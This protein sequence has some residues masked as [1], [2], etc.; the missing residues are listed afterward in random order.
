MASISSQDFF[1]SGNALAAGNAAAGVAVPSSQFFG[2]G[3]AQSTPAQT[4]PDQS[5]GMTIGPWFPSKQGDSPVRAGLKT[6]GNLI[7]SAVNSG[8]SGAKSVVQGLADIPK[9]PAA[10]V[11]AYKANG[12]SIFSTAANT[13]AGLYENA[14]PTA[15]QGL[16]TVGVGAVTKNQDKVTQGLQTAQKAVTNDPVGNIAPFLLLGREAAY[17][18]SPEAGASFD[19]AIH[20]VGAPGASAVN[21][22]ASILG[23]ILGFGGDVGKFAVSQATGFDPSTIEQ[24]INNPDSLSTEARAT[25]DR[26]TVAAGIKGALDAREEALGETGAAYNPIRQATGNVPAMINVEPDFL[27][28]QIQQHAGL[29]VDDEGDL[30]STGASSIRDPKDI[31]GMQSFYDRWQPYFEQGQMT[32]N[33]FLNMRSDLSDL[34]KFDREITK[35]GSLESASKGLRANLNNSYRGQIPG[36]EDT[37]ATY[38][39]QID[40]LQKLRKGILDRDGNLTDA[41]INKIANSTNKGRTVF[42]NQLEEIQPGITERVKALK[43]IEDIENTKG[44][45]VGT[46]A[47]ATV[48]GGGA[49]AAI[50][51]GNL[52]A[53]IGIAVT[54]ILSSPE[55]AVPLIRAYGHVKGF[56]SGVVDA[57][58]SGAS[59]VNNL[60]Q[61]A[62][63]LL[64]KFSPVKSASQT[65]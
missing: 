8:V 2:N 58:K 35:S 12:N 24:G 46:Y 57:L 53:L 7:P 27:Q 20:T 28:K 1:S 62:P 30:Q 54:T 41:G 50:A 56:T 55:V 44:Q 37:D 51:T 45:K 33:E 5:T 38:S 49:V 19:N 3:T 40:E 13:G 32:P 65:Q 9:I 64:G 10:A 6:L 17:K 63:S 16:L 61:G 39:S 60:P 52:P 42:L 25:I 26:P 34:S 11:A 4:T 43:A 23:K 14:V 47:R 59:T 15:A 48:E 29:T 36:L 31:R 22:A 18:V 21:A